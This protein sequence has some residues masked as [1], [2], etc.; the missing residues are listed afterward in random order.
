HEGYGFPIGGV[1]AFSMENGIISPGGVG[2]DINCTDGKTRVLSEFGHWKEIWEFEKE[3]QG[4]A[5]SSGNVMLKIYAEALERHP[6]PKFGSKAAEAKAR[7]VT[8]NTASKISE[9]KKLLYFMRKKCDTRMLKITAHSGISVEATE[10]HPFLTK[11]GMVKAGELKQGS[12]IAVHPFEGV[13]YEEP[14]ERE[15]VARSKISSETRAEELEKRGLLPL[16]E[17]SSATPYLAKIL[18]YLIGDGIVYFSRGKGY[19]CAYGKE[20]DLKRMKEDVA[21]LGYSAHIYSRKREHTIVDQY[22]TKNFKSHTYELH[23]KS[24]SFAELLVALGIPLGKKTEVDVCVPEWIEKAPLWMKRLFLAGFFGAEMSTP[25]ALSKTCFYAPMVSQNKNAHKLANG[26]AFMIQLMKLLE[27]FKVSVSK[28]AEREEFK[29]KSGKTLRLRLEIESNEENL[30]RLWK[31]IGFEYNEKRSRISAA[32]VLY[33][34]EKKRAREARE[35]VAKKVKE[36]KKKGLK[37]SEI[38]GLLSSKTANARFIA[39]RY[40]EGTPPRIAQNFV[41]FG[42]FL[43]EKEGEMHEFG[44]MFGEVEN[45]EEIE[46][47]EYVYDFTVDENHNFIANGFVVSNCGIRMIHTNLKASEV[48]PKMDELIGKLFQNVPS[49]VGS[50]SKL[51]VSRGGE[52]SD[53][54]HEGAR[55]AIEKGYGW[56]EDAEH[57][58]EKGGIGGALPE[59]VSDKAITRGLPQF[60]T[61]GAG[62]HFLEVQEVGEV[63]DEKTARVFGLEKGNAV[64]MLHCGSRGFGHQVCDDY[65]RVMINASAKYGIKLPD[66]ELC[67]APINSREASDYVG[68]MYCAVNY[69]FCNRQVMTHWIRE[70]FESMFKRSAEEMEMNV[71]Y[72][73]CHNIAK[74][75]E[76]EVQGKKQKVCVHRKGAT[77]AFCAGMKDVP[78]IY[79]EVGQPVLIPGSMG[80]ASYVLAG[81]ESGSEAFFSTCHGSGRVMSRHEAIRT[82]KDSDVRRDL[83]SRG[84]KI[85]ATSGDVI[86]EEAPGAYKNVDDVVQSVQ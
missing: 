50:K 5:V 73:V 12:K 54:L 35:E 40:Y 24:N 1:A 56:K 27:E 20:E 16:Y 83:E 70:T 60:G 21:Q 48:K 80:T 76:H 25:S 66:R 51:R 15:L 57:C 18:G 8:L 71:I 55:W 85:R 26:R 38:K 72:D 77:R 13:R 44:A 9:P 65:I 81:V 41:S 63:L 32:A 17:N 11:N 79:Q 47:P 14:E 49:G 37:I 30:L 52:F 3:A 42:K 6:V 68:A 86:S 34:E 33:V 78:S 46:R 4:E 53:A 39:R 31:N 75:E 61:L 23:V 36:Y 67:C 43:K 2:Y 82:Y 69:A 28:I 74:F 29:N 58:E 22:G 84:I 7:V 62:N 45:V 10:E 59:K 19:A 64:V